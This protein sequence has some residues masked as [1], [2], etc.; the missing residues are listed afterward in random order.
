MEMMKRKN[1]VATVK[2]EKMKG[3][4][5]RPC[6]KQQGVWWGKAAQL[7]QAGSRVHTEGARRYCGKEA[8]QGGREALMLNQPVGEDG[9]MLRMESRQW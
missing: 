2:M 5:G 9:R 4:E 1:K 3:L 8:E 6:S 7:K